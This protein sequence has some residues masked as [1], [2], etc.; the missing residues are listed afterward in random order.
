MGARGDYLAASPSIDRDLPRDLV[1]PTGKDVELSID[2]KSVDGGQLTY[3]WFKDDAPLNGE[4]SPSLSIPGATGAD[5][6]RVL[7][8]SDQQ[9]GR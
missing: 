1:V 8:Q 6:G 3:Q 4:V 9:Q 5:T 7:C 2:A